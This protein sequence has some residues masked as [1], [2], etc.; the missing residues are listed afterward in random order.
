VQQPFEETKKGGFL[1]FL[2]GTAKG[3]SGLVVKPISGTL[4]LFSMTAEGIKNTTKKE[5]DLIQDKRLRQPRPFYE[6]E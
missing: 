1:G 4:D 3:V 2:K 5:E 6:N